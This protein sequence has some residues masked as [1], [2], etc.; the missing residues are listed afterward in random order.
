MKEGIVY[1][2]GAGPGDPSLITLRG[3]QLIEEADVLVYDYLAH[4]KLL[5]FARPDVEKIYVGKMGGA[6]TRTQ[7]EINRIIIDLA[8]S[9]KKVARL[10]GGDPYIFGRGGEEA[11]E[12]VREGLKFEVVP[13][14]TAGAAAS[15]YAGIPLTHRDFTTDVAFVTGH[16]DPTKDASAI[17]WDKL[18]TGVGT[19]VF[20]MGIKNLPSIVKNLIDNGRDP[21]TPVA[22]IR[23]GARP[24]QRT[25]VG[26]LLTIADEVAKAGIKAPAITIV[27]GVVS[28]RD[29]LR[30]YDTKPLFG[31]SVVVTRAREQASDFAD[32][33]AEQ[34][35]NVIQFPT[36]ACVAPDDWTELDAAVDRIGDFDWI[37]FTSVNGVKFFLDR[38]RQRGKDIRVLAGLSICCIGPKTAAAVEALGVNVDVV[39]DEYRAEAVIEALRDRGG[40][41]GKKILIPRA[42]VAR[43]VLPTELAKMGADVT[44]ATAYVTVRPDARKEEIRRLFTDKKIDAITFTSSSTVTNFVQMWESPE[45]ARELLNGVTVA[46]I[47]PITS[48]T[49]RSYGIVPAV[50]PTDYT[51]PALAEALKAWFAD[52]PVGA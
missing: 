1:L 20:Y 46:S 35:A 52:Q 40:V 8:R 31:R 38:V 32:I 10:K 3:K 13:G 42:K 17:R 24:E 49:A 7:E 50:E 43:E 39:P 16:E 27:G 51:T 5:E 2:I 23:W 45:V 37:V 14:V 22:V 11:Q 25:V 26:T 9:G 44:V 29:E 18:A 28:L 30:W 12:L 47:G 48:D 33:L 15:A 19:L 34:G 36:I 6:H 41:D 21:E 4:P